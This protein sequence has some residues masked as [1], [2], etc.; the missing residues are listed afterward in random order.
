MKYL[1]I[2][3]LI[4]FSVLLLNSARAQENQ[5]EEEAWQIPVTV[6]NDGWLFYTNGRFGVA[7]P[8]PPGMKALRTPDNGGGQAFATIDGKVT[9]KGGGAFNIDEMGSVENRWKDALAEPNRTITY[10]VKKANWYVVSGVT[11][12][13]MGFYERYDANEKYTAGWSMTYPQ[14]DEKKYA[15]WIERIAKGYEPRFGKGFDGVEDD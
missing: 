10:K 11:K 15:P 1:P 8:V 14:V 7:F 13:G 12:A 3:L 5:E 6:G 4:A 2:F 9:L